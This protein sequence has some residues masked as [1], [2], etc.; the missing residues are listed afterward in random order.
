MNR[1]KIADL[2]FCET[3][4]EDSAKVEGG[5]SSFFSY[6]FPF[7]NFFLPIDESEVEILEE[8]VGKNGDKIRYFYDEETNSSGVVISK[9]TDSSKVMST[10]LGGDIYGGRYVKSVAFAS[11]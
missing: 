2:S 3:E 5:M 10:V 4:F 1:L 7:Q 6:S 8:L 11:S 9:E